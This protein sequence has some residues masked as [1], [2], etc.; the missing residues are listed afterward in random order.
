MRGNMP[1]LRSQNVIS[2]RAAHTTPELMTPLEESRK[3]IGF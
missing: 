1:S 2:S 3:G